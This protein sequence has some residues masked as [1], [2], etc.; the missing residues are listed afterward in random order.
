MMHALVVAMSGQGV[1]NAGLFQDLANPLLWTGTLI[2]ATPMILASTGG[3]ISERA[4]V[5]NIAMEGMM[6]IGAFFS[7][8]AVDI[9][10]DQHHMSAPLAVFLAI[11]VAMSCGCIIAA[12]HA[13]VCV[14]FHANQVV[15]GMAINSFALGL[16]GYLFF[17]LYPNP[18]GNLPGVALVRLPSFSLLGHHFG[19]LSDLSF[20]DLGQIAFGQ[21]PIV[22][23]A[24][25]VVILAHIFLFHTKTGLRIRAVGEHPRAADTAGI[26]VQ[27]LRFFAV[28]LSGAL[29]GLGGVFFSLNQGPALFNDNMTQGRGF[30]AL[31]AMIV[32]KWTPLGAL[33]AC[34][35]FGFGLSLAV[36]I[37]DNTIGPLALT[38]NLASMLPFIITIVAVTGIVGRSTPPAADGI[39]YDPAE[40]S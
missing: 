24:F 8:M 9:L 13:W 19:S 27:R 26:N 2:F 34:L 37:Q 25:L 30:I 6:L 10:F 40:S 22:Y 7:F 15:V 38:V 39:P 3:V 20:L 11:V 17:T 5:V 16:T 12:V 35:L 32:G 36:I 33:G 1:W 14:K 28:V 29:S 21:S 31:A 4:G 18:P 23:A